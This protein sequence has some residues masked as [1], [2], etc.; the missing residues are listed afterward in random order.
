[1]LTIDVLRRARN[2]GRVQ[3]Y[4][5]KRFDQLD[6]RFQYSTPNGGESI[7]AM[8]NR[9]VNDGERV[10]QV[11]LKEPK[12]EDYLDMVTEQQGQ[13]RIRNVESVNDFILD[14]EQENRERT[15]AQSLAE[16]ENTRT[17]VMTIDGGTRNSTRGT[18]RSKGEAKLASFV[19]G[20]IDE[21]RVK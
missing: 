6:T 1:L 8:M 17:L 3:A 5:R 10:I 14:V 11:M 13:Y 15:G 16:E 20:L 21:N 2:E 12:N 19:L 9:L 7:G 18:I 4:L